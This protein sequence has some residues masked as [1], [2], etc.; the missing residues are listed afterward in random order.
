MPFHLRDGK[1]W[2]RIGRAAAYHLEAEVK[3]VTPNL[4][5]QLAYGLEQ[6]GPE[7]I[8]RVVVGISKAISYRQ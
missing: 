7:Q 1:G 5:Q 6:N 2:C 8:G 4:F 3:T